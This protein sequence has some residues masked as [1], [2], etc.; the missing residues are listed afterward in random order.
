MR[1][2]PVM[3]SLLYDIAR[4]GGERSFFSGWPTYEA[5][6]RREMLTLKADPNSRSRCIAVLTEAG[7]K[8]S[9]VSQSTAA[10]P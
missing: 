8:A 1:L 2:S 4:A 5:L 7:W 3:K 6:R 9:G 10:L